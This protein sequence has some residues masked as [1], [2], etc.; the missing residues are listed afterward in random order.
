MRV[1]QAL[2]WLKDTLPSDRDRIV[3]RLSSILDDPKHGAVLRDDLRR[4]LS[5]LPSW[6]QTVV[7][8]LLNHGNERRKSRRTRNSA[9]P[10]SRGKRV[11]AP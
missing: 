8:E 5:T 4:G 11:Q 3:A 7:R 9:A 10:R 1:V 2:H 6:M